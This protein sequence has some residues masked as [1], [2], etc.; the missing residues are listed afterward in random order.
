[1]T[2]YRKKEKG[3]SKRN[4]LVDLLIQALDEA[5][6]MNDSED[7]STH[8]KTN[9]TSS[10]LSKMSEEQKETL[11]ISQALVMFLAA[12]DT[13]S[14]SLALTFHFLATNPECQEKLFEEINTAINDNDGNKE[15]NYEQLQKLEYAEA[16]LNES[17]RMY[18]F[19]GA[20]ERLCVKDYHIPEINF[21]V[22]KGMLVQIAYMMQD[23]QYY[24]NAKQFN[25]DNFSEEAKK[26]RSPYLFSSFGYGPRNCIGMRFAYLQMKMVLVHMI[27]SFKILPCEKTPKE[28]DPDPMNASMLPKEELCVA[29]EARV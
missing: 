11:M 29:L 23:D 4:D 9:A 21:T 7:I 2:L 5:S 10:Y 3:T 22:P 15:L 14:N 28:L 25:P 6:S 20:L 8:N 13:T 24:P 12:F 16:C 1:M 27:H 19:V 26:E 17:M 18:N